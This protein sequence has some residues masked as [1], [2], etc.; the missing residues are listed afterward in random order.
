M[1]HGP[2]KCS[3]LLYVATATLF[4]LSL[5][6]LMCLVCGSACSENSSGGDGGIDGGGDGGA[7]TQWS[8]VFEAEEAGW[9]FNVWA[10]ETGRRVLVG[11]EPS[12]GKAMWEENGEFVEID[13][14]LEV[15]LLNWTIGFSQN[16]LTIVGKDGTILN[17]DGALWTQQTSPTSETLWGVWG[18]AK[19]DLWAVGGNGD[20]SSEAVL[21]H[22]NGT[23]WEK[24]TLPQL[25]KENVFAFFK[26]WGTGANN[27]YVVGQHGVVLHW[28][29]TD[30]LEEDT[31][32]DQDLISIWGTD[33]DHIAAI[34]G[35][36][37]GVISTWN[38]SNW[39]TQSLSPQ[40][41]L[42]GVWMG[43]DL[44][45]HACGARGTL[46]RIDFDSLEF[47]DM[48]VNEVNSFHA[49][50][51]DSQNR[52]TAVGGSILSSK[53]PFDGLIYQRLLSTED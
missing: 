9:F 39:Q 47:E 5:L 36:G 1:F 2:Y 53:A 37:N 50:V 44:V 22:Y 16:S 7:S 48:R 43:S 27:V 42:N 20:D 4:K 21:I 46:L 3:R 49:M 10:D 34:G 8:S 6:L 26:V 23:T 18:S 31:G 12:V 41:G 40:P 25:Q 29:G 28:N 30:W 51:G 14:G 24:V 11:G 52:L 32:T 45:V 15:P 19:D 33:P 35:R 17:W 13:L 38:G